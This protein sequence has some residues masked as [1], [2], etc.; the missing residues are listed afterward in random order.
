MPA[1]ERMSEENFANN[2]G[3][4]VQCLAASED[5]QTKLFDVFDFESIEKPLLMVFTDDGTSENNLKINLIHSRVVDIR[6]NS[7]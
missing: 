4:L 6:A 3:M 7:K 2:H 1:L 5:R